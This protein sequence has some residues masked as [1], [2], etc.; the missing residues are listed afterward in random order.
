MAGSTPILARLYQPFQVV[1]SILRYRD[2]RRIFIISLVIFSILYAIA[3]GM[4]FKPSTRIPSNSFVDMDLAV[5]WPPGV[6]P[7]L[8]IVIDGSLVFSINLTA[9][10]F[11]SL[12][13]VLFAS[14][15]SLLVYMRRHAGDCCSYNS[16]TTMASV[17]PAMFSTF[18]CC[19]GG[20]TLALF[21]YIFS[22]GVASA[23]A[24]VIITYGW[25]L[26]LASALLLYWNLYRASRP[27]WQLASG[28]RGL[29]LSLRG[30]R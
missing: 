2:I 6:Y 12:L 3:S 14:N 21:T 7:W 18:A 29:R 22:L 27:L 11:L 30:L 16:N 5:G 8:T 28:H 26:A 19:G 9:F 1:K 15:M 17:V 23:Y 4:I 10:I 20:L 13:S 24:A 25:V